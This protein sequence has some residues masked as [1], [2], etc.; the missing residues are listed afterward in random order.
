MRKTDLCALAAAGG[1]L[2]GGLLPSAAQDASDAVVFD[3]LRDSLVFLAAEGETETGVPMRSTATGFFVGNGGRILTVYHLVAKLGNVRPDTIR[4]EARKRTKSAPPIP[5]DIVDADNIR[6]LLVLD[7]E[8][9]EAGR[10][11]CVDLTSGTPG[12]GARILSSG[13][14]EVLPYIAA[15]GTIISP[16]GP[17]GTWVTDIP[18]HAGQSGSPIFRQ[19]ARVVGLAKGQMQALDSTP[20][21]GLY[22]ALPI[23]DASDVVSTWALPADC[24][25]EAAAQPTGPPPAIPNEA[26]LVRACVTEQTKSMP[27]EPWTVSGGARAEGPGLNGGTVRDR[28]DVCYAAPPGYVIEGPVRV[29]DLGNNGGR[30]AISSVAYEGQLD[31]GAARACVTVEAWSENGLFTAGG[32]QNAELSGVLRKLATDEEIQQIEQACEQSIRQAFLPVQPPQ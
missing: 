15:S 6:D 17:N 19:D 1:L 26:A 10:A 12:L 9:G 5:A 30:G 7:I 20:I 32:W 13:F 24:D 29:R 28:R 8:D 27:R 2:A 22:I 31:A 4:I 23:S 11:A 3:R 16:D 25:F 18:F 14:P 21:P